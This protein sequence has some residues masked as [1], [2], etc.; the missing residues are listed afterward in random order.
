MPVTAI[1][2]FCMGA[3]TSGEHVHSSQYSPALDGLR[4]ICISVVLL[5]HLDPGGWFRGGYLGVSVFFALSGFLIVRNLATE[6]ST[7][8]RV[9][10][11]RFWSRRVQRLAPATL[12]T[13]A[14]VLVFTKITERGWSTNGLFGSTLAAAFSMMNGHVIHVGRQNVLYILGPLGPMWSLAVEEQFYFAIAVLFV[15]ARGRNTLRTVTIVLCAVTVASVAVSASLNDY[16]PRL[17]FGT[18]TRAAELALG[19]LLA[20][21]V[22]RWPTL[23][24]DRV[25]IKRAIGA[26]SLVVLVLLFTAVIGSPEVL[27]QGWIFVVALLSVAVIIALMTEGRLGRAASWPPLVALGRISFALYLVHWPIILITPAPILGQSGL[28]ANIVRAVMCLLT[29]WLLHVVVEQPM[30]KMRSTPCR[31]LLVWLSA[32]IALSA[33]AYAVL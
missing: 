29:A 17:E 19:G 22:H 7:T 11:V 31:I 20:L 30:R 33:V 26:V 3:R 9:D 4:A 21:A 2:S 23:F 16:L 6:V 8:G 24:T 13:V 14:A 15:V 27:F 12:A 28:R 10:V 25:V 5:Y 1:D 18:D 32:L